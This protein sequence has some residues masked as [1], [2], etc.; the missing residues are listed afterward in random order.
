MFTI[1]DVIYARCRRSVQ[2]NMTCHT[3][4]FVPRVTAEVKNQTMSCHSADMPLG[5]LA[6]SRMEDKSSFLAMVAR[7]RNVCTSVKAVVENLSR[8]GAERNEERPLDPLRHQKHSLRSSRFVSSTRRLFPRILNN[9]DA[10]NPTLWFLCVF[11]LLLLSWKMF[12]LSKCQGDVYAV[13]YIYTSNFVLNKSCT[14][15]C[16]R[17]TIYRHWRNYLRMFWTWNN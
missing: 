3:D 17:A 11:I 16:R 4:V 8:L 2:K 10:I 14:S 6:V 13:V 5:S 12:I 9:R 1:S 7:T 15:N